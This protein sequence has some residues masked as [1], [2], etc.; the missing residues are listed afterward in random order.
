MNMGKYI[1]G[2]QAKAPN[3]AYFKQQSS[4]MRP[5]ATF[6]KKMLRD[7][8]TKSLGQAIVFWWVRLEPRQPRSLQ[9]TGK[10]R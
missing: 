10:R 1:A 6:F 3:A 4:T 7:L 8:W 5:P 2:W 9:S